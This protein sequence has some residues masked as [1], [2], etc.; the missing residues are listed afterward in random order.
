[1]L[2]DALDRDSD[3]LNACVARVRAAGGLIA[4]DAVGEMARVNKIPAVQDPSKQYSDCTLG[5]AVQMARMSNEPAETIAHAALGGCALARM[6]Y[7]G[8]LARALGIILTPERAAQEEKETSGALIGHV[9]AA[10]AAAAG[11]TGEDAAHK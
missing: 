11:R 2:K 4:V 7:L 8:V 3:G 1:M 5:R 9:I 6:P 10:R